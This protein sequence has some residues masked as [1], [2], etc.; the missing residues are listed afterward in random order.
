MQHQDSIENHD[1]DEPG[2]ARIGPGD[3]LRVPHLK[4]ISPGAHLE[5]VFIPPKVPK[6]PMQVFVVMLLGTEPKRPD[7]GGHL[8][9]DAALKRL[10]WKPANQNLDQIAPER[11]ELAELVRSRLDVAAKQGESPRMEIRVIPEKLRCNGVKFRSLGAKKHRNK[12]REALRR[13]DAALVEATAT[14]LG[15][16]P[17]LVLDVVD[18][19]R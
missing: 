13:V 14:R 7:D 3:V 10:G 1:T 5:A 8:D 12:L 11:Q 15:G 2:I 6:Q 19:R 16:G 18:F 17:L 4:A 9:C